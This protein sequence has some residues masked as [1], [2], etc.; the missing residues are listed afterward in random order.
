MPRRFLGLVPPSVSALAV[1]L[2]ASHARAVG[3][4]DFVPLS[5]DDGAG[6]TLPY[7]L[8]VPTEYD[9]AGSYPLVVF[10]HG[11]GERGTDNV[12][13][14]AQTAP[15]VFADEVNQAMWP[16]FMLAPQC[17][18]DQQWVDM[19]WTLPSG[20]QPAEPTWPM[21]ATI[22]A[23]DEIAAQ[24][25]AIDADRIYVTGL[26]MGGFGTWDAAIRWPERF[27]A[28]V[29]IC[30][31]GDEAT[32]G[33][34]LET[35]IWAF[36]SSDDPIVSV[37]RTRHMI[38]ALTDLG[39]A[40]VYTEYCSVD[41]RGQMLPCY[42]HGSW[43]GAYAE[44]D[45]LPWLYA[46]QREAGPDATTGTADST[47]GSPGTGDDTG[48]DTTGGGTSSDDG[49]TGQVMSTSGDGSE[50]PASTTDDAQDTGDE[51]GC[52][53]DVDGSSA[54]WGA[55]LGVLHLRRRRRRG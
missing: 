47:G 55:A 17:P 20:V 54:P 7:R 10:F 3:V 14:L 1:C 36:H 53:C 18:P 42:G 37:D 15:L 26:S 27:A 6:H 8:F 31:G 30:G 24:Y 43:V 25:P 19:D 41:E 48:V 52:G 38:S 50:P 5:F 21:A 13:Q 16:A 28:A 12:S 34:I 32:V 44:P 23:I 22:A 29:P 9:P 51:A 4:D 11:A 2:H 46:Q 40:P 39:G 49:A 45:L 35:P 33:T